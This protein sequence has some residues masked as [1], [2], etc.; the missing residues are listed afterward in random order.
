MRSYIG[1]RQFLTKRSSTIKSL[2][3]LELDLIIIFGGGER[4]SFCR[5]DIVAVSRDSLRRNWTGGKNFGF[6]KRAKGGRQPSF[7]NA[8]ARGFEEAVA[9]S[10]SVPF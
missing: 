5:H 2:L 9:G 1:Y 6:R 7:H 10:V 4:S 3:A 8:G